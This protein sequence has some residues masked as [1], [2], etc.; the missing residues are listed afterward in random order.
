MTRT[1]AVTLFCLGTALPLRADD[2][3]PALVSG[4]WYADVRGPVPVMGTRYEYTFRKN[5][6]FQ[7]EILNDVP[8]PPASGKW[9]VVV[10]DGKSMLVLV[11][12]GDRAHLLPDESQVRYDK[13]KNVLLIRGED[14]AEMVLRFRKGR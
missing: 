3:S 14:G 8:N 13:A 1:A 6:T 5:G 11:T 4:I 10:K 12:K 7:A 9:R 2:V